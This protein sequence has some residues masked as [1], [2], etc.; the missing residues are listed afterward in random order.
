M[1][2]KHTMIQ[3]PS[4]L[5][6]LSLSAA[7]PG[8]RLAFQ[9]LQRSAAARGDVRNLVGYPQLLHGRD[10]VTAAHDGNRPRVLRHRLRHRQSALGERFHL[11]DSHG[12]IPHDGAGSADL[13]GKQ[14]PGLGSDIQPHLP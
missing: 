10:R 7:T 6:P 2:R 14:L 11:E 1:I 12:T 8:K 13:L 3:V 9:K 5:A 4:Y